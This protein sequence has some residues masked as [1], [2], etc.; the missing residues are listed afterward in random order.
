MNH[1]WTVG[2]LVLVVLGYVAAPC[3]GQLFGSRDLGSPLTPRERPS[4]S[5]AMAARN[6]PGESLLDRAVENAGTLDANARYLRGNRSATDFVGADLG[7]VN[8]FVGM[9]Q[10]EIDAPVRSAV[11]NLDVVTGPDANRAAQSAVGA[12]RLNPPRLQLGFDVTPPATSRADAQLTQRLASSLRV[13]EP[14][15]IAVSVE[16]RVATVRG[17]VASA[18]ER[19]LA[20]L[21]LQFEPGVSRVRNELV[22]QP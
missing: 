10:V 4:Q 3:Q 17:V 9:E 16:D 13:G 20:Q 15:R 19:S 6:E 18:R 12:T 1:R 2:A 22:V 7:D 11:E 14:N 21:L 8:G 5:G